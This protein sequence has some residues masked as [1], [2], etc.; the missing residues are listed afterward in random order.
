MPV[1]ST[2]SD[3]SEVVDSKP[4]DLLGNLSPDALPSFPTDS[5]KAQLTPTPD[6]GNT[7]KRSFFHNFRWLVLFAL[8]F[9]IFAAI[10]YFLNFAGKGLPGFAGKT[11][12]ATS[13]NL[14]E[15]VAPINV[16][17]VA[18]PS[19]FQRDIFL[20]NFQDA[21]KT[22]DNL[23][24]YKLLDDNYTRLLGFYT[25]DHDP[26]TRGV[27]EQYF[28]YMTGNF[29]DQAKKS[30]YTVPCYDLGCGKA[31][32]PDVIKGIK[33][34]IDGSSKIE[35]DLKENLDKNFEA[36]ALSSSSE[37]QFSYYE[38]VFQSLKGSYEKTKDNQIKGIAIKLRDF[39][40]ASYG[41]LYNVQLKYRPELFD[42]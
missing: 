36:A 39:I 13:G 31:N 26:R 10:I 6:P 33:E 34:E 22:N 14:A 40:K 37:A 38:Q 41:D 12:A 35:K 16:A 24:R 42:I 15:F 8:V 1:Q 19:D 9:L 11:P 7:P 17:D 27:V 21:A 5:A 23:S 3:K 25:Q 2:V 4:G 18:F 30:I 32:Y 29:P 20:K 28:A